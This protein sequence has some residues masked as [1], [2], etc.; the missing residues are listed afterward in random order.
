MVDS[1]IDRKANTT[2]SM[3]ITSTIS[4]PNVKSIVRAISTILHSQILEVYQLEN[5]INF[6]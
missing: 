1:N 4:A 3:Y 2:S 6:Y 5:F